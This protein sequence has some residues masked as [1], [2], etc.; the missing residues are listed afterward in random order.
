MRRK[1]RE[2]KDIAD[3][4]EIVKRCEVVH[5]AM[6]VDNKPYIVPVNFGYAYD[7]EQLE[8]YFHCAE[9][10]K[11]I[12]MLRINPNICFEMDCDHQ[13]IEG[14][15]ACAYGFQYS[16]VIGMGKADFVEDTELKKHYLNK[17][18]LNVA[19]KE[20]DFN[21]QQ[22]ANIAIVKITVSQISGK[23]RLAN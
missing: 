15:N 9:S 19:Q 1:D 18:M 23:Q 17:L 16:S 10:G 4:M 7:N 12:D 22:V 2:L 8:L 20:F 13:L 11:K 5:L 14:T 6:A 21:D 3:I